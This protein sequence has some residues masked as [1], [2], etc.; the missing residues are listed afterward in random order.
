MASVFKLPTSLRSYRFKR[1]VVNVTL[2]ALVL[3]VGS[4]AGTALGFATAGRQASTNANL[5]GAEPT[6]TRAAAV[7]MRPPVMVNGALDPSPRFVNAAPQADRPQVIEFA[8]PFDL[9]RENI[10]TAA[11]VSASVTGL[12]LGGTKLAGLA[13]ILC[14]Y[15]AKKRDDDWSKAL[16]SLGSFSL[17]SVNWLHFMLDKHKV[18]DHLQCH[19][20]EAWGKLPEGELKSMAT[21]VLDASVQ[22]VTSMGDAFGSFCHAASDTA[23]DFAKDLVGLNE[24]LKLTESISNAFERALAPAGKVIDIVMAPKSERR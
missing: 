4:Q 5:R 2:A 17:E 21:E 20:K 7:E 13:F 11:A 8:E 23:G 22:K 1:G 6:A 12:L 16:E 15:L 18:H 19:G 3:A 9:S 10:T 24:E 14:S